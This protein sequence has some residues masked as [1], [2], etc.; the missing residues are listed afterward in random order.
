MLSWRGFNAAGVG[1]MPAPRLPSGGA[2]PRGL[3]VTPRCPGLSAHL[4]NVVVGRWNLG[5]AGC[6]GRSLPYLQSCPGRGHGPGSPGIPCCR[7]VAALPLP[8][9]SS[10]LKK[11][12]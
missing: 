3:L 11:H 2:E 6:W 1:K 9:A 12:N 7:S 4:R 10:V 8:A 5:R